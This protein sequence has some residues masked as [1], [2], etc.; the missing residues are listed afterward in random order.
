MSEEEK[1]PIEEV[2]VD[3]TKHYRKYY[4]ELAG[5]RMKEVT[6][7]A[8][9]DKFNID[10]YDDAS[11]EWTTKLFVYRE[12]PT[13]KWMELEGLRSRYTDLEKIAATK[14]LAAKDQNTYDYAQ[15]LNKLLTE[16]YQKSAKYFLNM[17]EQEF[18]NSKWTQVKTIIDACNHRTI[19]TL[20][21]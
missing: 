10:I 6:K 9:E 15:Q 2:A 21:N 14:L 5:V 7:L 8:K 3:Y 19:F 17:E 11:G 13:K 12:I 1:T 20:P 16:L 4:E 18:D